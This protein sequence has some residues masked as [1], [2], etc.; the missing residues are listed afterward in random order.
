MYFFY[1]GFLLLRALNRWFKVQAH[2][3]QQHSVLVAEQNSLPIAPAAVATSGGPV[4]KKKGFAELLRFLLRPFRR[5]TLLWCILLLVTTHLAIV[6]LC[7]IV[8]LVQLA[9][10]V[11]VILKIMLFSDPWLRKSGSALLAGLQTALL[12]LAVV[13]ADTAPTNE[14][15]KLWNQLKV[16]KKILEFLKD[17]YL[18]SRWAWVLGIVFLG[19]IYTYIALLFSFAYYGISRVGGVSYSWPDALVTSFFIPFYVPDLPRLLA[20]RV[21]GG[22][23]CFLIVAVGIGTIAKFLRRKLDVIRRTATEWS[24]VFAEENVQSRYLILEQKFST[25][26]PA[27]PPLKDIEEK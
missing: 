8:V 18:L 1:W 12:G 24:E 27:G 23:H 20:L 10:K 13:T 17:P 22:L 16:W 19:C 4:G 14:L 25:N 21:L 5:F 6:W 11:S 15:K 9:R 7:L 26:N 3:Q 2:P